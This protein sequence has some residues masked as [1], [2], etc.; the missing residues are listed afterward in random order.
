MYA[1]L[2]AQ[3]KCQHKAEQNVDN[4]SMESRIILGVLESER[5]DAV[6]E[7]GRLKIAEDWWKIG[8]KEER[9][10]NGLGAMTMGEEKKPKKSYRDK[11]R[12]RHRAF[13]DKKYAKAAEVECSGEG[14]EE[15]VLTGLAEKPEDMDVD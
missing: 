4:L 3:F 7:Q 6:A 15:D 12:S 2:M 10:V 8:T 14:K 11:K 9:L 1:Q 13:L 5:A